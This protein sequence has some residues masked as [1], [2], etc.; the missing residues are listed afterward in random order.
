VIEKRHCYRYALGFTCALL[1]STAAYKFTAAE[2]ANYPKVGIE[3]RARI[4]S[5]LKD[6]FWTNAEFPPQGAPAITPASVAGT[7]H[8]KTY[9]PGKGGYDNTLEIAVKSG[10]LHVSISGSYSYRAN[11][12]ETMHDASG[13][14]DATLRG[15]VATASVTPDGGAGPCR[16]VIVFEGDKAQVKANKACE[17]NIVLDGTYIK[18]KHSARS[19]FRN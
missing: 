15:N 10:K 4:V 14:G 7:Y 16:V 11:G 1:A 5:S 3:G 9:R 17:F 19:T 8:Y 6:D 13:E 2:A 18:A 12:A